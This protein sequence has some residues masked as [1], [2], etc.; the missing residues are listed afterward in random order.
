MNNASALLFSPPGLLT[1]STRYIIA[2][3]LTLAL[4]APAVLALPEDREQPMHISAD[5]ALRD[6]SKGVTIYSGSVLMR[7]G[8]MELEAERITFYHSAERADQIVAQGN[9]AKMRQQPEPQKGLVHAEAEVIQ[10]FRQEQRVHLQSN[11]SIEQDGALV[12]GDS[13]DYFIDRQL[14][15]AQANENE[16][17]DKVIVVIPPD[18]QAEASAT[19]ST[20]SSNSP[21]QDTGASGATESQ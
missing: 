1:A 3:I 20:D 19:N 6:E 18:L 16:E 4:A 13:I 9:P 11:A 5:S 15:K 8:S 21:N 12:T 2:A 10:Y 14:V 7:Q 17:G